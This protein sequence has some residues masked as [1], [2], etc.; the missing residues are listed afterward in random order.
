MRRLRASSAAAVG[1]LLLAAAARLWMALQAG[2]HFPW[3]DS[4]LGYYGHGQV[5]LAYKLFSTAGSG[6]FPEA[7]RGPLFPS[8]IA[9]ASSAAKEASPAP[10]YLAQAAA[11]AAAAAACLAVAARLGGAPAG[12]L[13]ALWL[14]LDF[15]AVEAVVDLDVHG[16]YMACLFA[17][18]AAAS[19]W[20]ER[21]DRRFGA[22]LGAALG[23][24][25]LC[26]AAHFAVLPALAPAAVRWWGWKDGLRRCALVAAAA[27]LAYLP[28]QARSWFQFRTTQ[29]T[30]TRFGSWPLM[31]AAVGQV[32]APTV[33][34]AEAV[35][36]A[37]DPGFDAAPDRILRLKQ[38]AL[39]QILRHPARFALGWLKRVLY[40]LEPYWLGL[41]LGALA[42]WRIRRR[43]LTVLLV[44]AAGFV[45]GY[46]VIGQ[47]PRYRL[48][49]SPIVAVLGACG[50][51]C[52]ARRPPSPDRPRPWL[53]AAAGAAPALG[54]AAAL[55]FLALEYFLW[56]GW[57]SSPHALAAPHSAPRIASLWRAEMARTDGRFFDGPRYALLL[58]K[59]EPARAVP[60]LGLAERAVAEAGAGRGVPL[61]LALL[62]RAALER[63][64]GKKRAAD[65]DLERAL[66]LDPRLTAAGFAHAAAV[67][68]GMPD[69]GL[70]GAPATG[71]A[72]AVRHV[73][74][75]VVV[76]GPSA[77]AMARARAAA[78][79]LDAGAALKP[80]AR[81]ASDP[82]AAEHAVI[83]A[84]DLADA[85]SRAGR[86]EDAAAVLGAVEAADALPAARA[87]RKAALARRLEA[88]GD[89]AGAARELNAA[90]ESDPAAC[91]WA[92]PP[93]L[94][95]PEAERY[96]AACLPRAGK[97]RPRLLVDRGVALFAAGRLRR[98]REDFKSALDAD[99]GLLEAA[100]S[101]AAV[102]TGPDERRE[103][104]AR[105]AE[106]L[107]GWT[108]R[109]VEAARARRELSRLAAD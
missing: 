79:A 104:R 34:K 75:A 5:L 64:A 57:P 89:A 9:A 66:K 107:R 96:F 15:E 102:S 16:Y 23:V 47:T 18:A 38:T 28:F 97:R 84:A 67:A 17:A 11:G 99:R 7:W 50:A 82:R 63:A 10:V 59:L 44:F 72:A 41:A 105:L 81:A 60:L 73:P 46:A 42:A 8:F 85:L 37:V 48:P 35:A 30:D 36:R 70:P 109:E 95:T 6:L 88:S 101:L 14:T 45:G 103:A 56:G 53:E 106:A 40:M 92:A 24:A 51:F 55:L 65:R 32:M 43:G 29:V 108:G 39:R 4:D 13:A 76:P 12:L 77:L 2:S 25:A 61:S 69:R 27:A 93:S 19:R 78:A 20:A 58:A 33:E 87:R 26:R 86:P 31:T 54:Y 90:V 68:A 49:L 74:A 22:L 21:P 1:V 100:L 3:W 98:A 91:G 83:L 52:L 62:Q 94:W 80:L 71:Q